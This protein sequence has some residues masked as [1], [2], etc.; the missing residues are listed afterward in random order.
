VIAEDHRL[1]R[2]VGSA[3]ERLAK[4]R[5]HWTLN[6]RNSKRVSIR[7]YARQVGRNY[8]GIYT[9]AKGYAIHADQGILI[10]EAIGRAGMSAET[11]A[12]ADAVAQARKIALTTARQEYPTEVRRVR[13]IAR[14][15]AEEKGTSVEKEAPKVA[16]VVHALQQSDQAHKA[17]QKASRSAAYIAIERELVYALRNVKK[18]VEMA[19]GAKLGTEEVDLLQS[20]MNTIRTA[21]V[22]VDKALT[23]KDAR[24]DW[25]TEL[26][27]LT[28]RGK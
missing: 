1:E 17:R 27:V 13:E 22:L 11:E 16:K 28:E 14:E 26:K 21:L 20:T 3:S 18:A 25:D 7:E 6:E 5:W 12:A 8:N 23:G 4:L 9:Y 15:R 10:S 24:I 2:A 19:I